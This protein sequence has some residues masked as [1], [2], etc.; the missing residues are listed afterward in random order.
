VAG[1][2]DTTTFLAAW[3]QQTSI[4]YRIDA[5]EVILT[6]TVGSPVNLASHT[7][8]LAAPAVATTGNEAQLTA[9]QQQPSSEQDIYARAIR[10]GG[11]QTAT[12]TYDYDPLY[13]LTTAVYTGALSATYAYAYDG[14]GNRLVYTATLT[15]TEVITYAY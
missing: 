12:I 4:G 9:W 14:V 2:Q 3:R 15:S 1:R 8:N 11:L 5:Q 13:R 7:L 6:T 10:P